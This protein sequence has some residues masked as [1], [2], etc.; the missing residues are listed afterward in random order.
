MA[1]KPYSSQRKTPRSTPH[2]RSRLATVALRTVQVL[3]A[4]AVL[5][6]AGLAVAVGL[7]ASTL[8]SF[9]TLVKTPRG[10]LVTVR[11]VDG[12]VIATVG[13]A[14]G[15]WI[16][17]DRLPETIK[18][19]MV[20][21]EDRRFYSHIGVDPQGIARALQVNLAAGQFVQGG[22]TITQQVA[23]NV[24][25]TSERTFGRKAR[26]LVM[27]L[28]L[29][30]KFSKA[31][32]LELYLNR[33]Y[34]GGGAYGVDAASRRFFGHSARNLSLAE[35][36]VI[37]GLVKAPSR[38]AP[39][40]DSEQART[41]AK[42]V[43]AAMAETGRITPEDAAKSG[44]STLRFVK[45]PGQNSVRY[46]TD[47]ALAQLETLT[48]ET[49]EPLDVE[50][51]LDLR[52]QRAAEQ[53]IREQTPDGVQGALVAL[54]HDGA[55]RAM[56]GGRDYVSSTYNRAVISA[57]QPGSSFKLFVYLAALENGVSPDDIIEDSP[58][59][60][61][62]WSPRNDNRRYIGEVSV[63]DAFAK[64]INTVAVKLADEVGFNAVADMA[65][66]FGISTKISRLPAM[67]LGASEVKLIDMTTAYA[68]VAA[69]GVEVRP[70]AITRVSTASGRVVYRHEARAP[71]QLVAPEVA[72]SMTRLMENA[73]ATGTGRAAQIGRPVAGKTGTTTSNK[74][75][76][77]MGFTADL[78]AGVWM[79]RDD[80]RVVPGLAGG[81][82]PARAWAAFMKQA[83]EGQPA[84][85]L[86][87]DAQLE[88]LS[89]EEE[90]YGYAPEEDVVVED[91][92]VSDTPPETA[93]VQGEHAPEAQ[94][95]INDAWL[96]G[97]LQ[98]TPNPHQ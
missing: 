24:F 75:G 55:V 68:S 18:D 89:P 1:R 85:P 12:T 5:G 9:Q 47:W 59:T 90:A 61:D 86:Y 45:P 49:V 3:G 28:A 69:G 67:A 44:L 87:A 95:Q 65:R 91:P 31:Q 16:A 4:L 40:A 42:L 13:P 50:T 48:D 32:I 15:E 17:G 54:N 81:R 21:I 39:T 96:D 53:A 60:I 41:R 46:F 26:E 19:A 7:T 80:A 66:R 10:Q 38:Y 71:R 35:A 25:L 72:A 58:V 76:W 64:S 36:A 27:A 8:P 92:V 23:K 11:G 62:G 22:S 14:Y 73:V 97:V 98:S 52:M 63:R 29:E 88:A 51:T 94:P 77:F 37:A 57:R 34:F 33:V 20:S 83:T 82:T 74:D 84:A 30:W 2:R 70:Y 79:G 56:I 6:A 93:T 43:L 78:T